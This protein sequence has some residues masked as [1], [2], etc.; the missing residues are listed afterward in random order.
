VRI[1]PLQDEDASYAAEQGELIAATR[2][3]SVSLEWLAGATA[4][5]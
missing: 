5:I 3:R 1:I 2:R 4:A